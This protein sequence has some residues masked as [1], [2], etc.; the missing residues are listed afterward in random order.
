MWKL[1][2]KPD[3]AR[4]D[5]IAVSKLWAALPSPAPCLQPGKIGSR[6]VFYCHDLGRLKG[7]GETLSIDYITGTPIVTILAYF[8][9]LAG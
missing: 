4:N 1:S 3:C 9:P 2:L 6:D 8:T 5:R 7:E